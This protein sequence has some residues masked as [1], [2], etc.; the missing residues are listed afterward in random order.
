MGEQ[1]RP[2]GHGT[3]LTTVKETQEGMGTRQDALHTGGQISKQLRD[4]E[5][6]TFKSCL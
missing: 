4:I 2:S 3:Y 6:Q 5:R 1:G